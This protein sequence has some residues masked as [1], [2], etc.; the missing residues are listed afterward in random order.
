MKRWILQLRDYLWMTPAMY[1]ACA[2]LLSLFMFYVDVHY[3]GT[4][5]QVVPSV[6]LTSVELAKTIM[7]GLSSALLTMTTFTFSTIMVVLTTYSSQFSPRT[8]KNF[9]QD[10]MTWRVLGV[11]MAGFLYNTLSLLFM[12]DNLYNHMVLSAT[13]GILIALVCLAFFAVFIHHIATNIQASTLIDTLADDASS[14]IA[15][16]VELDREHGATAE[17]IASSAVEWPF[18]AEEDGYMQWMDFDGL[19]RF[20]T[21]NHAT[22]R[23]AVK[24]GDFVHHKQP[25]F[26]VYAAAEPELD[27]AAYMALGRERDTRLDPEFAVQKMVEVALRAISPGINDP[28]TAI[29]NIRHI[30]RLIGEMSVIQ[31]MYLLFRDDDGQPRVSYTLRT[32]PEMLY[33]TF[34]QMRHYGKEDVSVVASM[35][36]ALIIAAELAEPRVHTDIWTIQLYIL[37]GIKREELLSLDRDYLQQKINRLAKATGQEICVL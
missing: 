1:S 10:R 22:V 37:E 16:Y 28:N 8:L 4:L 11:F 24:I 36:D 27:V 18:C 14:V 32:F 20:A 7:G 33:H 21:A 19:A 2:V 9:V 3:T 23:I 5:E 35:T 13:V 25:V 34:F 31:S 30:G 17:E 12:R 15:H 26:F 29:H 6:L